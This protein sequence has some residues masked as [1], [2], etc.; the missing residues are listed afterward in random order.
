MDMKINSRLVVGL[1]KQKAWS[2]QQ[3]SIVS[4]VSLRTIQRVENEGNASLETVKSI[5]SAFETDIQTITKEPAKAKTFHSSALAAMAF[6]ATIVFGV[7]ATSSTT[8]ATGIEIQS[9]TVRQSYD[10]TET[11]FKGGVS[12]FIPENMAFEI[13]AIEHNDVLSD[14]PYQLRLTSKGMALSI[15]NARIIR[16]DEGVIIKAIE[17]KSSSVS[18]YRGG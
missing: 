5:A 18:P 4:G 2:Q 9:D 14:E 16:A 15:Q 1:R 17:V 3:L 11:G 10:K 8:A 6:F 13:S 12:V 7:L